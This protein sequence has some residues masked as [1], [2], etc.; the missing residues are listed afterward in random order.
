MG[1]NTKH[2]T[3]LTILTFKF[4]YVIE[5]QLNKLPN[6]VKKIIFVEL[7]QCVWNY[8]LG[9]GFRALKVVSF[10]SKILKD[11]IKGNF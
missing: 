8:I 3:I 6:L 5:I 7:E 4:L 1:T 10:H 9:K 2:V 11:Q